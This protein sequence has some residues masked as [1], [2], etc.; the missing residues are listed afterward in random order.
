MAAKGKVY[1][2]N[3]LTRK[4]ELLKPSKK[5]RV[6]FYSCGPTV[7]WYQHIG[8]M[9]AYTVWDVVKRVLAYNG[10]DVNHVMNYTDVGHLTSDADEGEDKIEKAAK[11]EGK[12]AKEIAQFYIDDFEE[13]SKLLNIIPPNHK[14]RATQYIRQMIEFI[15][16]LERKGYT[17]KTKDGVYFD[18]SKIKDYGI[19]IG[20][21]TAETI[22]AGKRVEV[23]EKKHP[24]D[25]ALWKFSDKPGLRQQEWESPFGVGWPGWHIECSVM[26][27]ALLGKVIDIHSGGQDHRQIH[28]PNEM[29]QNEGYFGKDIVKI[30]LHNGFLTTPEGDKI[31]KSKGGLATIKDLKRAG[32][33][34]LAVRYLY[35]STH[36]RKPLIFS[37]DT[38]EAAEN[39]YYSIIEK[40]REIKEKSGEFEVR[41][42]KIKPYMDTFRKAINDDINIPQAL[43]IL[44]GVIS[45][46][47]LNEAEKYQ[48]II[49]FDSV[50]GLGLD[51]VE[52]IIIP[53]SIKK[54][55]DEREAARR[56]KNWKKADELRNKIKREGYIIE[57]TEEGYRIIK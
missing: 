42:G 7:Y 9:R 30:W 46:K 51:E 19:L 27:S 36:Y 45:D 24:T 26:G 33:E 37:K 6:S 5:D 16:E 34:P 41:D 21:I 20:G 3:S 8:N 15:K 23:G 49:D 14:P 57:D 25:F 13:Q 17:Y 22:E 53:E 32:H 52:K 39:V 4:K 29:A 43:A 56:K 35:L 28:H 55:A 40:V 12:T 47:K 38:L 11:K 48:L 50:L 1:L 2:Y 18:T 44:H 10:Y 31:S 54:L